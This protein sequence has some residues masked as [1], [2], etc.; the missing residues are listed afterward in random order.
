MSPDI[1]LDVSGCSNV[2]ATLVQGNMDVFVDTMVEFFRNEAVR[3]AYRND[4]TAYVERFLTDALD[5]DVE[6]GEPASYAAGAEGYVAIADLGWDQYVNGGM[7]DG[8]AEFIASA[9]ADRFSRPIDHDAKPRRDLGAANRNPRTPNSRRQGTDAMKARS[10][11]L[12]PKAKA[13]AKSKAASV[14]KRRR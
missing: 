12:R 7:I 3:R 11:T 14:S 8:D 10:R 1:E 4:L 9:N 5:I 2:G 6:N 13:P